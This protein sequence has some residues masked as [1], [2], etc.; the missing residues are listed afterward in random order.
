MNKS[1]PT[2]Y[3]IRKSIYVGNVRPPNKRTTESILLP[4]PP[5]SLL[6]L[7]FHTPPIV[8]AQQ[9]HLV[10]KNNISKLRA[11]LFVKISSGW[12]LEC[13]GGGVGGCLCHMTIVTLDVLI[14]KEQKMAKFQIC[15]LF[16]RLHSQTKTSYMILYL[17]MVFLQKAK[18]KFS[19]NHKT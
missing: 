18:K 15:Q 9:N 4:P 6:L 14:L 2:I 19:E 8:T 12:M 7:L 1:Y 5:P 3:F 13:R 16:F 10:T 11:H 17:M